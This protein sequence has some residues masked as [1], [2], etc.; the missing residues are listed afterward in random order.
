MHPLDSRA[1]HPGLTHTLR[2]AELSKAQVQ[3]LE[4]DDLDESDTS[5]DEVRWIPS[6][7]LRGAGPLSRL[8]CPRLGGGLSS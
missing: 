2:P 6:R 8:G 7:T 4:S 3:W 1:P 5:D